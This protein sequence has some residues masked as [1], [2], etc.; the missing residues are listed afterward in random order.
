MHGY[1]I[2]VALADFCKFGKATL[3]WVRTERFLT[4]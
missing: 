3:D 1:G 2:C 4:G